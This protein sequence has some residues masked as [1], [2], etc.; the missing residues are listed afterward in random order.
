MINLLVA[1]SKPAWKFVDDVHATPLGALAT[2]TQQGPSVGQRIETISTT[3]AAPR[4]I[5]VPEEDDDI[6][7]AVLRLRDQICDKSNLTREQVAALLGVDRRSLTN[8]VN[9]SSPPTQE[10]MAGLRRLADLITHLSPMFG[11]S[12]S[13]LLT[14]DDAIGDTVAYVRRGE[15]MYNLRRTLHQ[16]AP[17]AT[18]ETASFFIQVTADQVDTLKNAM[19]G[20]ANARVIEIQEPEESDD[21]DE[22]TE[23]S[24]LKWDPARFAPRSARKA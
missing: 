24:S 18:D 9:G 10:H 17:P 11:P 12:I 19:K 3:T 2:T 20:L 8:W 16:Y 23:S 4:G 13:D 7:R 1:P 14:D 22:P 15:T 21:P 6:A 5:V